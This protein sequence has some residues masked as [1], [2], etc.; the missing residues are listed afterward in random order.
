M[1]KTIIYQNRSEQL[2]D[3]PI[4]NSL[5]FYTIEVNYIAKIIQVKYSNEAQVPT[6]FRQ[7]TQR[8]WVVETAL[9]DNIVIT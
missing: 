2:Q 9:K 3:E 1:I 5:G 4:Q 7:M 6:A 8:A